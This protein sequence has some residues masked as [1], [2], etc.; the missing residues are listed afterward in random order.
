M[1]FRHCPVPWKISGFSPSSEVFEI[2]HRHFGTIQ[3]YLIRFCCV[4][5][6]SGDLFTAP[7]RLVVI[8]FGRVC[9]Y[10]VWKFCT[11]KSLPSEKFSSIS[12]RFRELVASRVAHIK[13]KGESFLDGS[14]R[15][16]VASAHM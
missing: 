13:S 7:V 12:Q 3:E 5:G 4:L 6:R 10:G 8:V 9:I 2:Y 16:G 1:H 14:G 11:C 15:I